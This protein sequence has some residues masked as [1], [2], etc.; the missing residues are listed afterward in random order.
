MHRLFTLAALALGASGAL[1]QS[2]IIVN[3][4]PGGGLDATARM[5]A[6]KLTEGT[7]RSF[8]VENRTGAAGTIG[9]AALKGGPTDGSL[10]LFAPDSNISVYPHTVK[11]PSYVPLR[12]FVGVAHGGN[13]RIG[14]AVANAV[15]SRDLREFVAWSKAQPAAVGYGTAG[16]GTNLHFLGTLIVQ[17]TGANMTHIPY[18]GTIP[19]LTD[20][21]AGHVQ[22]AVLPL[23]SMLGH[24]R[25]GKLRFLGQTGDDRS[26]SAP[27]APTF[28]EAGYP[29][30]SISG[31]YGLFAPVGTPADV[32]NRYNE[33]VVKAIRTPD[34]RD[35]LRKYELDPREMSATEFQAMVKADT[36][37]WEP[38]I[39]SSG[40]TPGAE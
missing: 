36:E 3:Y 14:L 16:A 23:G 24:M 22:A 37:R 25:S 4:P 30:L 26:A 8:V 13:Y 2:R 12:D 32:L 10:L 21:V 35:R 31:W 38:I 40:F 7:G 20:L 9:A 18:R 17:V 34:G 29:A 27:D 28:K 39:R 6:E 19:A 15:P 1:A 5:L 33:V 11:N